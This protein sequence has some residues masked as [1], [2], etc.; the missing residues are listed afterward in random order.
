MTVV[1]FL[2]GD[3]TTLDIAAEDVVMQDATADSIIFS[4]V[5]SPAQ[6]SL[7]S[8]SQGTFAVDI[9]GDGSA[10]TPGYIANGNI[11][12]YERVGNRVFISIILA[13]NTLAGASGNLIS[14]GLPYVSA[15]LGGGIYSN[16]SWDIGINFGS[17]LNVLP[18]TTAAVPVVADVSIPVARISQGSN[19]IS[20]FT[21]N[22]V[23]GA[24]TPYPVSS[25]A[26]GSFYINGFYEV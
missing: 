16:L 12:K 9:A 20:I 7:D 10:G 18:S 22:T 25:A 6:T 26:T 21:Y 17:V 2:N 14:L 3:L 24:N 1:G 19:S 11:G 5:L 8:Y 15:N 23:T 4:P 13:W